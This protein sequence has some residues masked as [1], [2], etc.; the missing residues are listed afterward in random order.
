MGDQIEKKIWSPSDPLLPF[1]AKYSRFLRGSDLFRKPDFCLRSDPLSFPFFGNVF[2]QFLA[3]KMENSGENDPRKWKKLEAQYLHP[4]QKMDKIFVQNASFF[5][6]EIPASNFG[7][8]LPEKGKVF[9]SCHNPKM[10]NTKA[11]FH[12]LPKSMPKWSFTP[13]SAIAEAGKRHSGTPADIPSG[14][15]TQLPTG[16]GRTHRAS[17]LALRMLPAPKHLEALERIAGCPFS[18][19]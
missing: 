19:C 4:S 1:L 3:K 2:L 8:F 9:S 5:F 6:A 7:V 13:P 17:S 12:S 10:K 11:C 18:P 15:L 14:T 16:W